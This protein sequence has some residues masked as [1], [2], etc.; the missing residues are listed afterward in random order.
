[1]KAAEELMHRARQMD[2]GALPAEEPLFVLRAQDALAA[3]VVKM[4]CAIAQING[5]PEFKIK[6]AWA[7]AEQ[8]EAWPRKQLPGSGTSMKKPLPA[9][10]QDMTE[11]E[12]AEHMNRM[13]RYIHS[14]ETEDTLSS[15]LVI[16]QTDKITQYGATRKLSNIPQALRELADRLERKDTVQR[17]DSIV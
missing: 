13:L 12:L 9:L 5:V 2:S 7:L 3:H 16:F 17:G 1:M 6:E 14:C 11:P 15:L 10:L 8:M 4:W